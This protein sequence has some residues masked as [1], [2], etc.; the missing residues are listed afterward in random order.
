MQPN[1]VDNLSVLCGLDW[2]LAIVNRASLKTTM[3]TSREAH[4]LLYRNFMF[5]PNA[6]RQAKCSFL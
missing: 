6:I 1:M 4:K 3:H 2:R 5:G